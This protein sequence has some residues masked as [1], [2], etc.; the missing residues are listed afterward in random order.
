MPFFLFQKRTV[1]NCGEVRKRKKTD[2]FGAREST[3]NY[4][5][6]FEDLQQESV[7]NETEEILIV[8]STPVLEK[9]I[10]SQTDSTEDVISLH[11][12]FNLVKT[13]VEKIDHL[14]KHINE[15]DDHIIKLDV[16]I[17]NQQCRSVNP[18]KKIEMTK[19]KSF[20]LPVESL[21]DLEKLNSTLKT[22]DEFTDKL[23]SVCVFF[24]IESVWSEFC[25]LY[26]EMLFMV[27]HEY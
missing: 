10:T 1:R 16:I 8:D 21:A 6:F 26:L 17:K 19:L 2:R 27:Y 24:L 23:V 20:D 15:M 25:V 12:L 7:P 9:T 22:N 4:N 13:S 18:N 11:T 14:Q 3:S 5:H